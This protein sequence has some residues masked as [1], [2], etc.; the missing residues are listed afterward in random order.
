MN[1]CPSGIYINRKKM[2]VWSFSRRGYTK[3]TVVNVIS[4][5][6]NATPTD[7]LGK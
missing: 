2:V 5:T 4:A 1:N 6:L 7:I 3:I